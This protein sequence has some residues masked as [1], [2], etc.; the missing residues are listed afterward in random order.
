MKTL[1]H[2][3]EVTITTEKEGKEMISIS[4]QGKKIEIRPDILQRIEGINPQSVKISTHM[5]VGSTIPNNWLEDHE[6][7]VSFDYG[8]LKL[9]GTKDET[10][11]VFSCGR[12]HI[13]GKKVTYFEWFIPEGDHKNRW[14]V[15]RDNIP[16]DE[17]DEPQIIE[18]MLAPRR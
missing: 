7:I 16:A 13:R 1:G 14:R 6:F 10:I 18:R 2:D 12:L 17:K 9:H 3:I 4:Q 5:P 8:D 15:Y 11:E